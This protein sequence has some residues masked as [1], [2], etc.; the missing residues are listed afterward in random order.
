MRIIAGTWGGRRIDAPGGRETRPTA[1]RVREAWMS[2]L[3]ADLPDADVLDLFAGSG[4]LGLEAVS[5]GASAATF[6]ERAPAALKVLRANIAA[7]GAGERARVVAGDAFRFVEGLDA[8]AFD[9]ALADPPYGGGLAAGLVEQFRRTPFARL[10]VVEHRRG[11][12]LP[13]VPDARERRYGD[14]RLTFI[15]APV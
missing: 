3:A 4:A 10:L 8:Y 14:T 5:R 6:V 15:P 13:P 9:V 12:E 1:D 11:E 7:L 2:A